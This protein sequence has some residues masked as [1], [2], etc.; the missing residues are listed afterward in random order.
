MYRKKEKHLVFNTKRNRKI[1]TPCCNKSNKDS[2]FVTYKDYPEIY[3]YCHSCGKTT[4]PPTIYVDDFGNEYSWNNNTKA[5]ENAIQLYDKPVLQNSDSIATDGENIVTK[6]L[7]NVKYIDFQLVKLMLDSVP[8]NNLLLYLR[9]QYCNKIVDAVKQL[10][11]IGTSKTNGTVMWSVNIN[12]K[13]QKAKVFFYDKKGRRKQYFKVP[14]KNEDGYYSCLFGEHLLNKN[15]KPIVLVESEKT[16]I[17]CAINFP[18]YNWLSYGGINGMTNDKMKVLSGKAILIVP[19]FSENARSITNKK[20]EELKTL[21]IEAKMWDL[22]D[23]M[24][25]IELNLKGF[26]NMDLEDFLRIS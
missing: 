11:Y 17:V 24:S 6:E 7:I 14:Y 22:S 12:N 18:D 5:F 1:I 21:N 23:G 13:V 3:G 19:D 8:E 20:I 16:A 15:D 10:Y 26:Y 9:Q 4:L 25:D 2:K